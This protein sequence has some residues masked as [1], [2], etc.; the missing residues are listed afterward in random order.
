MLS[1][2]DV[3][4]HFRVQQWA[5][6]SS[7]QLTANCIAVKDVSNTKSNWFEDHQPQR[8]QIP[9]VTYAPFNQNWPPLLTA[10]ASFLSIFF[11]L[12]RYPSFLAY[13]ATK[14]DLI[15]PA[16][17]LRFADFT[18][19]FW[20]RCKFSFLEE[21]IWVKF[22]I[23]V[24]SWTN[25]SSLLCIATNEIVS[26]FIDCQRCHRCLPKWEKASFQ[27]FEKDFEIKKL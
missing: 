2:T 16:F 18:V 8:T 21:P 25:H 13:K 9:T 3:P 1:G 10:T 15:F 14:T 22:D 23:G 5:K 11:Q 20:F 24:I 7:L 19:L 6:Y 17:Y 26:F 4:V 12:L 27:V